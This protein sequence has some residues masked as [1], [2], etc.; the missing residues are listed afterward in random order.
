MSTQVQVIFYSS[1]GHTWQMAEAAAAGAREVEGVEASLWQV[2]ELVPDD[3]LEKS[4]AKAARARFAHIP[5]AEVA[6]L[7]HADAIIFGTP[8]RFGN[9]CAQMRNFLD[10]TGGRGQIGEDVGGPAPQHR[11]TAARRQR[12]G[13]GRCIREFSA[14]AAAACHPRR[15]RSAQDQ[16]GQLSVGWLG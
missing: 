11:R 8:T 16:S 9:M 1:Y 15:H 13:K 5:T 2:P 3:V 4:G 7:S 6:Q 14:L 12:D 10:Q